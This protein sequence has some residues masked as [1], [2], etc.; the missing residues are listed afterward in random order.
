VTT[1]SGLFACLMAMGTLLVA[2]QASATPLFFPASGSDTV[3]TTSADDQAF[4]PLNLGFSFP[5][6]GVSQTQAFVSSN[7]L[8]SFGAGNTTFTNQALPSTGNL[9]APFWDDLFLPPGSLESNNSTAGVFAAIW[10]GVGCFSATCNN[11]LEAVLLGAG[12]PFGA[13]A[14]TIVFSYSGMSGTN[15]GSAT[16]G[17][18]NGASF[19]TLFSLGIGN[20]NGTV[21]NGDTTGSLAN[22]TFT[23]TP[24][25]DVTGAPTYTVAAN[26]TSPVP[27]PSTLTL[28]GLGG[29]ALIRR[30]RGR[31]GRN[32]RS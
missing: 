2:T 5:F 22:H 21:G 28:L 25:L 12:N 27:E 10:N 14:G 24:G 18:T 9:I 13:A 4:G 31:V 3:L 8:V 26:G 7:G 30:F 23:F 32:G 15:D 6:F 19:A 29:V 17:L 20:A 16:V 11:T 1:K